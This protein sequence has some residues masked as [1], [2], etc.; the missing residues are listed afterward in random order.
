M[1]VNAKGIANANNICWIDVP[2]KRIC[3]PVECE[4]YGSYQAEGKN[5]R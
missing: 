4:K 5:R 3:V 1:T 2:E